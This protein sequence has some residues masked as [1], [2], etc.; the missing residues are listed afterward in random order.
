[1]VFD[2]TMKRKTF[3]IIIGVFI[4]LGLLVFLGLPYYKAN[5]EEGI[6]EFDNIYKPECERLGGL[7]LE[8]GTNHHNNCYINKS[9][10]LYKT[11][12]VEINGEWYLQG[13]RFLIS[14]CEVQD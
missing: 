5:L 4:V 13:D 10:I 9:G 3:L 6:K 12:I 2:D 7:Y 1:V 11:L 8:S 14:K